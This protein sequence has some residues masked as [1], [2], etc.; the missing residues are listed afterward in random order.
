MGPPEG[1]PER[2]CPV[3][4]GRGRLRAPAAALRPPGGVRL[5]ASSFVRVTPEARARRRAGRPLAAVR[6]D[7]WR[8]GDSPRDPPRDVRL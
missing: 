4:R 6:A 2:V 5:L 3:L 8:C 1:Q 7:Q